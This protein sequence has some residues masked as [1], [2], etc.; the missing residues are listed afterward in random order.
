MGLMKLRKGEW[1]LMIFNLA[2]II[3]FG[4]YYISIKNYEFLWYVG[5]LVFFFLLIGLTLHRSKFDYLILW[6]LSL[7]GLMH[8][9]GG[10]IRLGDSVLYAWR[11]IPIINSGDI[12]ILKFDQ[13]VHFFGFGVTT[14][15]AYHLLKPY[16]N[17]ETNY[18]IIYPLLVAVSMGLGALNEIVEFAAVVSF[19]ETGVGG[20][21]NTALDLLFN[22]LGAIAAIFVIHFRRKKV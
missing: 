19:P 9:A 8:M 5:V 14:L 3:G 2:Y 20:Y 18:K 21:Y 4:A 6:G 10:G 13:F 17:E 12:F 7:W 11:M 1:F 15:I 16:L 22:M